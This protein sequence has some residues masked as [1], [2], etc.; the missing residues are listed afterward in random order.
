[1]LLLP[2]TTSS[3]KEITLTQGLKAL[4]SADDFDRLSRHYWQALWN[5]RHWY[6]VRSGRGG[7]LLYM[8][9]VITGAEPGQDVDHRDRTATLD[10]RRG[11][12]RIASRSQ[13]Q[14]NRGRL[15]SNSIGYTGVR[16]KP[17]GKFVGAVVKL[18][19]RFY[20]KVQDTVEQA[21]R[22]RD[23]LAQELFGEFAAMTTQE[24][25]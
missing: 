16:R 1:M 25:A 11:N 17:S 5:G 21:A 13:N 24:A 14:A 20:T 7:K 9:R 22:A 4:V 18:G 6:A 23:V 10:N 19:R 2:S 8:H 15:R 12:L 3:D